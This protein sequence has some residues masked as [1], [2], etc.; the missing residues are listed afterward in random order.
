MASE[1]DIYRKFQRALNAM[2]R[3]GRKE[4]TDQGH[5][6]SGAGRDSIEGVIT[7]R[8]LDRL[9]GAIMANDYMV[10]DVD[11]FTPGNQFPLSGAARQRLINDLT[12]WAGDIKPGLVLSERIRFAVNTANKFVQEGRP[13]KASKRFAKN[14]RRTGWITNSFEDPEAIEE[15]EELTDLIEFFTEL[16]E[17]DLEEAA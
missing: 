11:Q 16:F 2:A 4:V 7:N 15:F 5:V 6:A 9:I 14:G 3:R 17:E 12:K 1:R 13:T 8:N 10:E